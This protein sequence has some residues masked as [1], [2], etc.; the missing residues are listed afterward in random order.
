MRAVQLTAFGNPVEALQFVQ[1]QEPAAPGPGQVLIGVDFAP[2][3]L[4]DLL[5]ARGA[6][7]L[8]PALPSVIGNEGVGRVLALGPGVE[9]V[10]VGDRV[11]TP[12]YAFA[13]AER[14]VAPA[15]GLFALPGDVDPQQL[16]M[17][18]INPPTA[19]LLLSEFVDLAPGDWVVQNAANSGVG[20]AVI[21]FA[22]ARGFKTINLVRRSELIDEL[23]ALG[24][25]LV[26]VDAPEGLDLVK[27][28]LGSAAPRLAIDG[29]G[30]P[31]AANLINLLG[32]DG[33]FVAYAA[34]GKAPIPISALDLI[35]KRITVRGFFVSDPEHAAKIR[36][37][38]IEAAELLR[39]GQL[40]A[41]V[42][43]TYPLSAIKDAVAH[44]ERGGK[45]LLDVGA[46]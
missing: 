21:A 26:I 2:I 9:N 15:E 37:F 33:V 31:S 19:A 24:G 40:R 14:I 43:A 1:I 17:L 3:D 18:T 22:K 29:V 25:D 30:G 5:V 36:P 38:V 7:P 13:W 10:T 44:V 39:S 27:G 16:A 35:F 46:S 8:R 45:V 20:R 12:L 6:Y 41:P 4:S 28:A 32:R 34:L 11:L 23:K 42:A